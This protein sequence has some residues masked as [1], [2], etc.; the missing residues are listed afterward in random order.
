MSLKLSD[1]LSDPLVQV[2][3]NSLIR[4]E[5]VPKLEQYRVD[6]NPVI[7]TLADTKSLDS[8]TAAVLAAEEMVRGFDAKTW[9]PF[10]PEPIQHL[11]GLLTAEVKSPMEHLAMLINDG[12]PS[13]L[14]IAAAGVAFGS[15]GETFKS[16]KRMLSPEELSRTADALV[17]TSIPL[18]DKLA[19]EKNFRHVSPQLLVLLVEGLNNLQHHVTDDGMK[20]AMTA[21][22]ANLKSEV[23]Q[24]IRLPKS[25][26]P[27][28]P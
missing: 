20:S 3:I 14:K 4:A 5:G 19:I 17:G 18:V 2:T 21:S 22:I 27:P 25:V 7:R 11:V 26:K 12:A 23:T 16:V 15:T 8:H 24:E 13:A 10:V 1:F 6:S 28:K 9:A